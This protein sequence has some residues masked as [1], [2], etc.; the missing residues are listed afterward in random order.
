MHFRTCNDI[1]I[2]YGDRDA[3][4]IPSF[5]SPIVTQTNVAVAVGNRHDS[6]TELAIAA[7]RWISRDDSFEAAT[8]AQ[9]RAACTHPT[10]RGSVHN[11]MTVR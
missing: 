11:P 1:G 6:P 8:R 9:R 2:V 7:A 3:A 10:T 5:P 4:D